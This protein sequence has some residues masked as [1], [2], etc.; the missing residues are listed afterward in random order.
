MSDSQTTTPS[1]EYDTAL[2][3]YFLHVYDLMASGVGIAAAL[4]IILSLVG[5]QV[6]F[7]ASWVGII[8]FIV[9]GIFYLTPG[10]VREMPP[11]KA[12]GWFYAFAAITGMM[13]GPTIALHAT[14]DLLLAFFAAAGTFAGASL[15]G[16]VTKR[17]LSGLLPY[18]M[19]ALVGLIFVMIGELLLIWI[20]GGTWAWLH[21]IIGI[22]GVVLF[23]ILTAVETWLL[24]KE[25]DEM[26]G[27][28]NPELAQTMAVNAAM[29]LFINF[30]NLF[31][32][33]LRMFGINTGK[34][35]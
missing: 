17:E 1:V 3:A 33:F 20:T 23:T 19:V 28:D 11:S 27:R 24:R 35:D 26:G 6:M 16:H 21:V 2:R 5:G 12:R 34:S 18:L 7:V 32:F 25:F 22:A 9:L 31:L 10:R 15:Y 4:S 14:G 8:A 30:V 13:L 29:M